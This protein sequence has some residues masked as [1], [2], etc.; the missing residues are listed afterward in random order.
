MCPLLLT[1]LPPL[2]NSYNECSH[3]ILYRSYETVDKQLRSCA[4]EMMKEVR[5]GLTDPLS[6]TKPPVLQ[7][8]NG[9]WRLWTAYNQMLTAGT[10]IAL[11]TDGRME[12]IVMSADGIETPATL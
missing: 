6:I 8:K 4:E 10:Y 12:R 7:W 2:Y 9:Q 1:S 5:L 11:H 3:C